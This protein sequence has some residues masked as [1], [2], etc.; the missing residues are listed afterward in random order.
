LFIIFTHKTASF[1][2]GFCPSVCKK[3]NAVMDK[4]GISPLVATILLIALSVG[5]GVAVMSWGEAYIE[6]KAE[7][8]QGVQETVTSCDLV[9]FSIIRIAGV[10]QLCVADGAVKGLIDNGPDTNIAEIHARIV[11]DAGIGV[12]E[13]VLDRP[14]ARGSAAQVEFN[15]AGIISQVKFTPKVVIAGK[16]VVCSRQAI[17]VENIRAC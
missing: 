1:I 4:K 6:E 15:A 5:M 3:R 13:N 9:S 17:V 8:V 12:V 10:D 14:L 7:F 11:S 2:N 16:T